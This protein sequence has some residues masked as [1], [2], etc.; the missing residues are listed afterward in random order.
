MSV[1]VQ[2]ILGSCVRSAF[3]KVEERSCQRLRKC[4]GEGRSQKLLATMGASKTNDQ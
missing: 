3:G 1:R 4:T 2:Q